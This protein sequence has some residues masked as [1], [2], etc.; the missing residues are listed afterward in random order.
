MS[1]RV[2]TTLTFT[3]EFLKLP[4]EEQMNEQIAAMEIVARNGGTFEA[5]IVVPSTHS[6]LVTAVYPDEQASLKAHLQVEARG[7]YHLAPQRAYTLE[8]WQAIVQQARDEAV[9]GV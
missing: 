1:Y 9:V 3:P 2:V 4:E 5:I 8:E 7:A 6:S